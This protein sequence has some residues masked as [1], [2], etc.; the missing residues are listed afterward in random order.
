MPHHRA[1]LKTFPPTLFAFAIV[2]LLLLCPSMTQADEIA[3]WNFND[4][5]FDVDHGAGTLT[6]NF[7]PANLLFT[8]AGTTIN[9]RQGDP[10]GQSLTLQGGTSNINNGRYL[11][12]A[13]S[14]VGHNNIVISFAIQTTSTGF[15]DN[16]FQ[17]SLDGINFQ[18]FGATIVPPVGFALF[19]F[20]LSSVAGLNNNPDAAFRIVF[21]GS[22][23][24]IGNNRIDNFV[25]EGDAESA[26]AVP[27]PA[28]LLLL[29]LGLSGV[30]ARLR[31][32]MKRTQ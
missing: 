14:T 4:S 25:V 18:N 2:A 10:A 11:N 28:S 15:F 9:G 17:Y 23:T 3:V 29:G 32:R 7:T 27:E 16:Q 6:T 30:A 13:V 19:S 1:T 20:D 26:A 8:L 22:T 5:D 12:F 21:D 31:H 24:S